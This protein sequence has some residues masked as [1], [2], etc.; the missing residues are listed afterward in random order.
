MLNISEEALK[1]LLEKRKGIIERKKFNGLNNIVTGMSFIL[2][3]I[4]G[5]FS[6]IKYINAQWVQLFFWLFSVMFLISG[7]YQLVKE[8]KMPYSIDNLYNEIAD[9]DPKIEH[10]FD[11]VAIKSNDGSGKYL[12]FK[13]ERWKCWLF[14]NYHCLEEIPFNE[15]KESRHLRQNIV[16]DLN[17]NETINIKYIGNFVS[18]KYSYGDKVQKKY[19]FHVFDVKLVN[20]NIASNK[21][22]RFGGKTYCWKTLDQMYADKNIVKKNKDVL[23]YLRQKLEIC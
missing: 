4:L 18:Q 20:T 14:P 5:D 8:W 6:K 10:A 19:R 9:L 3:L 21:K 11:I 17:I 13:N 15:T 22:F 23:D 12:I 1:Q 7:I 2:T 16:R